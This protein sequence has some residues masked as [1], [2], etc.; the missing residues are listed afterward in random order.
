MSETLTLPPPAC[1]LAGAWNAVTTLRDDTKS[2]YFYIYAGDDPV[3]AID[4][5]GM[6]WTGLCWA[7]HAYR[8]G[9]KHLSVEISAKY[10]GPPGICIAGGIEVQHG[11]IGHPYVG[12]GV[13]VPG[14]GGG[15]SFHAQEAHSGWGGLGECSAGNGRVSITDRWRVGLGLGAYESTPTCSLMLTYTGR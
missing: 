3:N 4:P 14:G 1:A 8:W 6:C 7:S 10:C 12:V 5:S 13:G 2:E 9:A 11:H 15:I